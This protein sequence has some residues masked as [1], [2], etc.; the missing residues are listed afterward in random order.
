MSANQKLKLFY[1]AKI[2]MEYT[3]DEHA[4]TMPEIIQ[5]L[6]EYD[7]SA[8]RKTLYSDFAELKHFG[9][10]IISTLI[11]IWAAASSS[12]PS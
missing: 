7:I 4:L 12:W 8:E 1:L 9:L 6:K 2:F 5:K 11:I 3:D 10:D